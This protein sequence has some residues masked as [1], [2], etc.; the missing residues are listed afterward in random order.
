MSARQPL[1]LLACA[2]VAGGVS[3]T[4]TKQRGFTATVARAG[5]GNYTITLDGGG[6]DATESIENL[7]VRGATLS[8]FSIVHTSDTAKQILMTDAAGTALDAD[9]SVSFS[10]FLQ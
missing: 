9:F 10:R 2:I 5:A 7:Q 1:Q 6:I 8:H 4:Y 3:P